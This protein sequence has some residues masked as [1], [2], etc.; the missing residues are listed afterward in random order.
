MRWSRLDRLVAMSGLAVLVASFLPWYRSGWARGFGAS[1]TYETDLATAWGSSSLWSL[2]VLLCI[3]ATISWFGLS[4][5]RPA[6]RLLVPAFIA[7]TGLLVVVA[8]WV[9]MLL[10]EPSGWYWTTGDSS[11]D[12]QFDVVRDE[13]IRYHEKG[14]DLDV[15][16][17][18]YVGLAAM[19][20]HVIV[21]AIAGWR[22]RQRRAALT[23]S[24]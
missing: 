17:G 20:A 15:Y 4:S 22:T 16:W 2:G 19:A 11:R 5:G 13:L 14:R 7:L 12:D 23:R 8:V 6:R 18:F 24:A 1:A 3:A 9:D 21:L 10:W